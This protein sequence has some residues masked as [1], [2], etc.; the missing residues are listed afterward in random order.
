MSNV[1][2][3]SLLRSYVIS[4][5]IIISFLYTDEKFNVDTKIK[6]NLLELGT[7][8]KINILFVNNSSSIF[9]SAYSPS[10]YF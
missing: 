4:T 9:N 8:L 5:P 7:K 3:I 10:F 6:L 2:L 1:K